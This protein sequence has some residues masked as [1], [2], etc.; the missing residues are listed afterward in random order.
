[1]QVSVEGFIPLHCNL[2]QLNLF[3]RFSNRALRY[4]D[5]YRKGLDGKEAAWA[6]R[7]YCGHRGLPAE[8]TKEM[9]VEQMNQKK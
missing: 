7:K 5:G 8:A 6:N 1:M 9:I 3:Q 2:F 4:E